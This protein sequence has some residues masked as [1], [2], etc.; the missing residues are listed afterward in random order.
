MRPPT[1]GSGSDSASAAIA[2]R[3]VAGSGLHGSSVTAAPARRQKA[4][5]KAGAEV[6]R[7]PPGAGGK[8]RV[9]LKALARGLAKRGL[10]S[11]LVEGGGDTHEAFLKAGLGDRLLLYVAPMALGGST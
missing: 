4:L 7:L 3:A 9:D 2:S 10:L 5:E 1:S 8:H 6:W 11:V